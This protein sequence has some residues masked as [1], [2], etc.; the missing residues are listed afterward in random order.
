MA[1]LFSPIAV[2]QHTLSPVFESLYNLFATVVIWQ[3]SLKR[4][5][6]IFLQLSYFVFFL[7]CVSMWHNML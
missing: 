5:K 1:T 7:H 6:D 2:W 3:Q 4:Y